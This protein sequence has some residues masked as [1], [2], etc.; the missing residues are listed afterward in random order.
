MEDGMNKCWE[1]GLFLMCLSVGE[2]TN[3]EEVGD[4]MRKEGK[5]IGGNQILNNS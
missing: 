1:A 4:G 5:I 2:Q 3:R